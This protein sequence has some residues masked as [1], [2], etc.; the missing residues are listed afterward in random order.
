M[1]YTR[2]RA[3]KRKGGVMVRSH[4]RRIVGS[5]AKGRT[6]ERFKKLQQKVA[7]FYVGKIVPERYRYKYG[8]TYSRAE[9]EEVGKAVAGKRFWAIEGKRR[10]SKILRRER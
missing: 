3:F 2:V 5:R 4:L 10:G 9:A 7:R 6:G 1:P 8:K